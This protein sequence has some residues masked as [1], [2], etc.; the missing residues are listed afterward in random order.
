MVRAVVSGGEI[1][2]LDPLPSDWQEGQSL[3]VEKAEDGEPSVADIDRDFAVLASLCES[4][5]PAD[6]E[7]LE[8]ALQKA[9][10]EAK[11]QVR[12]QMRSETACESD[13][14][15][16]Q[17]GRATEPGIILLLVASSSTNMTQCLAQ[18]SRYPSWFLV[19][20]GCVPLPRPREVTSRGPK[21]ARAS[22]LPLRT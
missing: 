12:R 18:N 21:R 22:D 14:R 6:E 10:R 5:D 7:R 4:S 19:R 15:H 17:L 13:A 11:E 16:A 8:R 1:R 20:P 9:H 2:P 3:R